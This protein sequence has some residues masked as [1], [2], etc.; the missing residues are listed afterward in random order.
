MPPPI[1]RRDSVLD[2][3]YSAP[4]PPPHRLR[5][6]SVEG[7]APHGG[8]F[9]YGV[10]EESRGQKEEGEEGEDGG[11][12]PSPE[13]PGSSS[14]HGERGGAA[15]QQTPSPSVG[16]GAGED[17]G[18]FA[19]HCSSWDVL[20]EGGGGG[21]DGGGGPG[22]G[23]QAVFLRPEDLGVLLIFVSMVRRDCCAT[24]G[25][26]SMRMFSWRKG[27]MAGGLW[28]LSLAVCGVCSSHDP[29]I[30]RTVSAV[31]DGH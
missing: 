7:A 10:L 15:T 3:S 9:E 19:T 28:R 16:G 25:L 4:A 27:R 6:T 11:R 22:G 14:L 18:R 26:L 23:L 21:G 13:L 1:S 20:R 17:T 2:A 29:L 24:I 30:T 8:A 12:S 5:Q 31:H